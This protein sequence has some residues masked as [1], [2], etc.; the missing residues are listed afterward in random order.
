MGVIPAKANPDIRFLAAF[1]GFSRFM[2][3]APL[4]RSDLLPPDPA[5][6]SPFDGKIRKGG[7]RFF[8]SNFCYE[9]EKQLK[10]ATVIYRRF[11]YAHIKDVRHLIAQGRHYQSSPAIFI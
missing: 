4:S 8:V 2:D 3:A 1:A 9:F 7:T 5:R 11:S 10:D 6:H